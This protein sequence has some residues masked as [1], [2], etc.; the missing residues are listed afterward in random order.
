MLEGGVWTNTTRL[1]IGSEYASFGNNQFIVSN[2]VYRGIFPMIG[3]YGT[4][5]S[6]NLVH[7]MGAKAKFEITSM[8]SAAGQ[9]WMMFPKS[10][11]NRFILSDG[12]AWTNLTVGKALY[13]SGSERGC[14]NIFAVVRGA[15]YYSTNNLFIASNDY[16]VRSNTLFVADGALLH[17]RE[18]ASSSIDN[19]I[20]ASNATIET[21]GRLLFSDTSY[22]TQMHGYSNCWM[23]VQGTRPQV[24]VG[25]SMIV[26]NSSFLHFDLPV[27]MY[28]EGV[29][30]IT[31]GTTFNVEDKSRIYVNGVEEMAEAMKRP[32]NVVLLEAEGG[33]TLANGVL[34]A[35]NAHIA[36][37]AEKSVGSMLRLSG[38]SKRLVLHVSYPN[39]T[40]IMI[41]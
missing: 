32:Y 25:T 26:R 38:D 34:A 9:T 19:G 16:D 10:H 3:Y 2:G 24:K 41:K 4:V 15:E 37:Q 8:D 30:P 28:E 7:I 17:A 35:A 12:V 33:I 31:C 11:G 5:T 1:A 29:V 23:R 13:F 39:G 20:V 6:N 21:T 36:A 14:S 40:M 18:I 22:S 27:G